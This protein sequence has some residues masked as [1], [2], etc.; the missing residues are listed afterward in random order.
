ME[1][2]SA[3][4]RRVGQVLRTGANTAPPTSRDQWWTLRRWESTKVGELFGADL[5][6]LALFRIA[7]ATIV[8]MDVVGRIPNLRVH[9]SDEGVMPRSLL[10]DDFVRWRWSVNLIND[11]YTFQ[12]ACMVLTAAAAVGMMLGYRT[13]LMTVIVWVMVTSIQVRNPLVL[14]GADTLLRVLL[15]WSMFLPLG[16]YWS[17]DARRRPTGVRLQRRFLSFGTIGLFMQ[18]CLMYWFTA[19]L[20]SGPEWRSEGT[21]L[22]Y[23]LGA[24]HIT[25]PFGEWLHQFPDLLKVLTHASL[26]LEFVAPVLLFSP[27][28]TGPIRTMAIASIVSLH[29][30]IFL[31]MDVGIFPWTSSFCMAAFLPAWFWDTALQ[32]VQA[33]MPRGVRSRGRTWRTALEPRLAHAVDVVRRY[34]PQRYPMFAVDGGALGASTASAPHGAKRT[35]ASRSRHKGTEDRRAVVRSWPI[36]NLFLAG[37]LV[38]VVLWNWTSVSDFRMPAEARPFAYAS[39]LYQRWNM[40]APHPSKGTVWVV[41]RGVLANGQQVDLLTPIVHN[42]LGRVP[43]VSWDEPGDIVGEYYGDKYWRKYLTAITQDGYSDERRAFAAY[44]CRTW[45][46]YYGGDVELAGLQIIKMSQRT[47]PNYEEAPTRRSVLSEFRCV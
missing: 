42:D 16:A 27:F 3:F 10:V 8:L 2:A 44:S 29:V 22:Y 13:R 38:F 35:P 41:V 46:N 34:L 15:F 45:N 30:G 14:S 5:R 11:L 23:A 43:D 32:R 1:K 12:A 4:G 40:F 24:N 31:T 47:L 17:V 18:I 7:M 37:C 6:S 25:K 21:A 26:G 36:T 33:A 28:L 20:K 39:G 9:Y 19:T